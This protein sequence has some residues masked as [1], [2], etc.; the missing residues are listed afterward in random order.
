MKPTEIDPDL[1]QE[2]GFLILRNVIPPDRLGD[3]R[4]QFEILVERQK[5]IWARDRGPE[6]PPGGAWETRPQ[7]RVT[8][9]DR[10]DAATA[11]TVSFCLGE[12]TFE[13]SRRLMAAP[14]AAVHAMYLMCSPVRDHG[15]AQW[16]RDVGPG[17]DR[18]SVV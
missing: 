18:K 14:E 1:F 5:A 4:R 12:T 3:M 9:C 2:Q 11:D 6:E 13:V 17:Q 7:P 8:F 16:H 10:I 15:P